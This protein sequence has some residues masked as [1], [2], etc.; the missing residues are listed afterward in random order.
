[1]KKHQFR[2]TIDHL[3]DPAGL[4][5]AEEI[6]RSFTVFNH[7][8]L[9]EIIDLMRQRSDFDEATATE[10]AVGLKLFGEAMLNNR[11]HPLFA[12]FSPHFR[13]FMKELKK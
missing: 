3:S 10:L 7:D 4:P 12:E 11:D 5:P 6:S 13:A 1:M 2:I 9:F 8:N